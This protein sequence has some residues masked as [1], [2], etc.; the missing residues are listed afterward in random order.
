MNKRLTAILVVILCMALTVAV[1]ISVSATEGDGSVSSVESVSSDSSVASSSEETSSLTSS[2]TAASSDSEMSS[3]QVTSS[4]ESN[5][6]EEETS[7]DSEVSSEEATGSEEETSSQETSSKKPITSGGA[8]DGNTFI[9]QTGSELAS[10]N[11]VSGTGDDEPISSDYAEGVEDE[12]GDEY[13]GNTSFVSDK[14]Y[15]IIWI[16]IVFAVLCI[17]GLV[18]V[19]ILFRKKYPKAKA[20]ASRRGRSS[21]YEAPKR[22]NQK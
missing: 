1:G 16:P 17:A 21:S 3:E 13:Q 14:I 5:S 15:K 10:D 7:S 9:E 11:S 19:N 6:S 4:E 8:H 2:E 12:I 22:R 20:G 18:V